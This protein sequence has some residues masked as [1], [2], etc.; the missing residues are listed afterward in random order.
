[1]RPVLAGT[2]LVAGLLAALGQAPWGLWWLALGG[3]ALVLHLVSRARAA[4]AGFWRGW[5]A[6]VGAFGLSMVWIVEPFL[7]EPDRHAWMAP[8]AL[9]LLVSGMALFWGLAG[10][11]AV[12]LGGARPAA[13]LWAL[14]LA[15]LAF[16][17]LRG[18]LFTGFP[19]AML[20]HIWIDTPLGQ[21]AALSGALGLSALTLVL[22]AVLAQAGGALWQAWRGASRRGP[23]AALGGLAAAI[24]VLVGGWLWGAARLAQPTL[25]APDLLVRLVQPNA[26]QALKWDPRHAEALFFRHL[27]L[28]A[29]PAPAG[30]APDLVIWPETAVPFFLDSAGDGLSMAAEA[31]GGAP[32]VLGIQRRERRAEGAGQA[33]APAYFNSLAVLDSRGAPLAVYDKHH[34]VPFGEY[35]PLLGRYADRPG[36]AWLS[37]FAA[38]ALLGYSPGPGPR[39]LDLGAAGRVLPLICYE[40][41]FPRNLR[42]AERADW[43]LQITNDAWFGA[44]IGPFQ[45][46]AQARLRAIEQGLPMVRVANTGVSAVIDARGRVVVALG[47]NRQGVIDAAVPGGASPPL[48]A[49]FGDT[50]WHLGLGMLLACWVL[51]RLRRKQLTRGH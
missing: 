36:L 2:L 37:G 22:A 8:F 20:G 27:E 41:I 38:Q 15:M 12:W 7:I 40:A 42:T 6:G 33:G 1:M 21:L 32:L 4:R 23:A 14:V 44:R 5:L 48:H 16:E 11:L 31:A 26:D 24:A 50:P 19:W 3:L 10:A 35:V 46:L 30:R 29:A 49:R 13:R 39:L 18:H 45:H 47:M 28:T 51:L 34:L 9:V 43:L 17:A 25:P